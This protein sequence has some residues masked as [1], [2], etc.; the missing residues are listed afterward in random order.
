MVVEFM[1]SKM[2]HFNYLTDYETALIVS[3][4]H[5]HLNDAFR[6][7]MKW[8]A[9]RKRGHSEV[10]IKQARIKKGCEPS[11]SQRTIPETTFGYNFVGCFC[12]YVMPNFTQLYKVYQRYVKFGI[13]PDGCSFYEQ[14]A[15]LIEAFEV[16]EILENERKAEEAEKQNKQ[17]R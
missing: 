2:Y 3:S 16:I 1:C 9:Q 7:E 17:K 10:A 12:R 14:P 15:K 11:A 13:F 6:C 4:Y 8:D 5:Y